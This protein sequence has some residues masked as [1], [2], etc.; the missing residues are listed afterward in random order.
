MAASQQGLSGRRERAGPFG[1][2]LLIHG[3]HIFHQSNLHLRLSGVTL[4]DLDE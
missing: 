3:S 2:R 4:A 1:G